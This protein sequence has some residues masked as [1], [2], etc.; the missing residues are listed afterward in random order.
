M[1]SECLTNP[2]GRANGT[3]AAGAAGATGAV[4]ILLSLNSAEEA[5]YN[6]AC[7]LYS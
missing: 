2:G 4:A 6:P 3:G 7:H 5:C 1:M